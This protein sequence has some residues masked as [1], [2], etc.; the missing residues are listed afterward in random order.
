MNYVP[1]QNRKVQEEA[2]DAFQIQMLWKQQRDF[3][4]LKWPSLFFQFLKNLSPF[5][6]HFVT[7][8]REY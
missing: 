8:N 6:C 5:L 3:V 1:N 4:I 2:T 7:Y